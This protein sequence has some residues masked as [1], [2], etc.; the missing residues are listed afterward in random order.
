VQ[1]VRDDEDDYNRTLLGRPLPDDFVARFALPRIGAGGDHGNNNY[2]LPFPE[3]VEASRGVGVV[4]FSPDRDGVYR[5][6][7]L[8]RHYG[9]AAF[10][11]LSLAGLLDRYEP[12]GERPG[13]LLLQ[14]KDG[15]TRQVP[16]L[17][18]EN[19]LIKM[20]QEFP[21]Y[22]MSGLLASMQRLL[23]GELSDLP[24]D[25]ALFADK[26]VYV[27]ASAVGVE[28]LKTTALG[29][30]APGVL[31][32]ASIYANIIQND[33]L[34]TLPHWGDVAITAVLA[35]IV[36]ALV[37]LNARPGVQTG[38]PL[39]LLLLFLPA[40]Q[41]AYSQNL[42]LTVATP[43]FAMGCSWIGAY[44]WVSATEGR[45]KRKIRRMLGQYVSPAILESVVDRSKA[46]VLRA[47]VGSRENL[48]ILF[49]DIRGFT[50]LSESLPAEQVVE[51][52]NGYFSVMVD[53][54]FQRQGTLDKFIGDAIMAFWGAPLKADDHPLRGVL[55]A[56]EMRDGLVQYN[57]ELVERGLRPLAIGIGLHTGEMILGNI[58]SEKKLDYTVIGDNVNLGSRLE[59]L[60]KAYGC[61]VI[62]SE[63]VEVAVRETIL[64]RMVDNVR[65]KGKK[66]PV[67]IY[68]PLALPESESEVLEAL[69]HLKQ[70][71]DAAFERYLERDWEGAKKGYGDVLAQ[72][73]GDAL[74]TLFIE[75]CTHYQQEEP[76]AEW[77]G[78]FTLLTK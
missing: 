48:T 68:E 1:L 23:Q 47:E 18:D 27:G 43:L 69:A 8:I 71:T 30:L 28:D 70:L 75:R 46:G 34:R 15:T 52:L 3:L 16:L 9:E 24:L 60:T 44:A 4:E 42:V 20:Y 58:G 12:L 66:L 50:S 64:C 2:Y 51:L 57:A 63:T 37:L 72:R 25:P 61:S 19:Y 33:F 54:I 35:L 77:D 6:T 41:F 56:L 29:R 65:V 31:L 7:R 49:S 73:P 55:A 26:V 5:R 10:P 67:R 13:E 76:P 39:L 22:S 59:G 78:V 40:I 74:A 17:A 21:I 62:I 38:G 45:D 36:A 14:G 53:I 32:H 11:T